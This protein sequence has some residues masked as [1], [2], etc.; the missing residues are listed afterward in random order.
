MK[1]KKWGMVERV[2]T[3][4]EGIKGH[5]EENSVRKTETME[6]QNEKNLERDLHGIQ[7]RGWDGHRH[8][9]RGSARKELSITL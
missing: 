4:T 6:S 8:E 9:G 1:N 5:Q 2:T 7:G 3:G